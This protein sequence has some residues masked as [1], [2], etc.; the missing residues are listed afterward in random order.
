MSHSKLMLPILAVIVG[1]AASAFTADFQG[2]RDTTYFKYLGTT[3]AGY[4]DANNWDASSTQPTGCVNGDKTCVV[5]SDAFT[6][7][8]A[9]A[10]YLQN[11][12]P[13][14]P[15]GTTYKIIDRDADLQP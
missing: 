2:K 6:T 15:D 1:I 8:Q 5:S 4:T 10:S 13:Q 3:E 9:L 7:K 14:T 11:H 12:N